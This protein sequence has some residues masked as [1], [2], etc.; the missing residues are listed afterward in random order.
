MWWAEA[1]APSLNPEVGGDKM[2]VIMNPDL[3]GS[4][5]QVERSSAD[6]SEEIMESISGLLLLG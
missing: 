1:K 6:W 4:D 2:S 5:L 3:M